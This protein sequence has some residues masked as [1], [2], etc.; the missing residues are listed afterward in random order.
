MNLD[1]TI[2]FDL[3]SPPEPRSGSWR[4]YVEGVARSLEAR[5]ARLN[6]ADLLIHSNVPVGAGL[7]SSAALEISV[8]MALLSIAG[9]TMDG[10]SVAL[11]GQ[12]AE[13][14]YVGIKC[15]I[16]DQ[17]VA[18]MGAGGHALLIDCRA[19]ESTPVRIGFRA[20]AIR[21]VRHGGEARPCGF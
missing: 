10:K 13:H 17:Y 15:G 12:A 11:A 7:S 8:G 16:M 3:G 4:D 20:I 5:G 19:I 6:G 2:E 18:A 21:G 1:E 9:L 14:N